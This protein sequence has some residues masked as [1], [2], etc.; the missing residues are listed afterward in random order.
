MSDESES[1]R[2]GNVGTR[3]ATPSDAI[4]LARLRYTFRSSLG[5]VCES[6]ESFVERCTLWM[7]ER[8]E[9][10]DLWK[11]WV[12][13]CGDVPV[14][15]LWA[16]LIEKVPNPASEPEYHAYL[17]N[18]YVREDYCGQGIGS[19]LLSA[20][21]AWIQTNDVHAVILWPTERSRSFYLRR[22]FSVRE[23]LM[24]LIIRT[25]NNESAKWSPR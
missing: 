16:Q 19:L 14:G 7:Q 2:Q 24:E 9:K 23:D 3:I 18:F 4:K 5:Q 12:A 15:N 1:Q 8:L 13:E 20:A 17:T 22:G 11:C 25:G 21:L 10:A 6:D